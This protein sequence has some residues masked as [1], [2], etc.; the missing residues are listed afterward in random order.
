VSTSIRLST[1]SASGPSS[2]GCS[3]S[4]ASA[5]GAVYAIDGVQGLLVEQRLGEL[6]AEL[7]GEMVVADAGATQRGG[8]GALPQ[9]P[10]RLGG[11]GAGE[12][13]QDARDVVGGQPVR[14]HPDF[15][16]AIRP[17]RLRRFSWA[18]AA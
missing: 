16:S 3:G 17:P 8:T 14:C 15:S 7:P 4:R 11:G 2:Y 1:A 10:D 12:G 9:G 13:F 18:L 5:A 6:A